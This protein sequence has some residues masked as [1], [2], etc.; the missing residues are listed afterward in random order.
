MSKNFVS[1]IWGY[2]EHMY[3]FS[4]EENYHLHILEIA[5]KI[6]LSTHIILKGNKKNIEQDPN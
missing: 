4:K 3:G 1:I 2:S 6:G 5:Q